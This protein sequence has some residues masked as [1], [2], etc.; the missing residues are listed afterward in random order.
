MN[1]KPSFQQEIRDLLTNC[2]IGFEDHSESYKE[3]DF[4]INF[5]GAI[6]HLDVKEKI[7]KYQTANWP[8]IV[9]ESEMFILDDL[10]VRKCL[11]YAPNRAFLSGII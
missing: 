1:T 8:K 11:A 3:L 10:S 4:I 2:R 6:F 9:P 5:S 7:Q